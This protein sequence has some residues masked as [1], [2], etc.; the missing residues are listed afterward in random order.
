M[1]R[2]AQPVPDGFELDPVTGM[3]RVKARNPF[4]IDASGSPITSPA[5]VAAQQ[6]ALPT[7][8]TTTTQATSAAPATTGA[9]F[10]MPTAAVSTANARN[11]DDP[12]RQGPAGP[13]TEPGTGGGTNP[14][15]S[16]GTGTGDRTGDR[17]ATTG[18]APPTFTAAST[19][20]ELADFLN[21]NRFTPDQA[22]DIVLQYVKAHGLSGNQGNPNGTDWGVYDTARQKYYVPNADVRNENGTWTVHPW[23]T[24]DNSTSTG[25]PTFQP[26]QED[27]AWH[28]AILK[29]LEEGNTPVDANDPIIKAQTDAARVA[30]TREIATA[31]NAAAERAA[32]EGLPTGAFD[33][34]I[35]G[36]QE[37][38]GENL[39]GLQATLMANELQARRAK[40]VNALNFASGEDARSL[41]AYL[42]NIDAVL[43]SLG[44]TNQNQQHYDDLA[45]EYL[46]EQD[47]MRR[48]YDSQS[49]P[50]SGA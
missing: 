43:R 27:P 50:P 47:L 40:V 35:T 19:P 41:Q 26:W 15:G 3:P 48:F 44:L 23:G 4:A 11:P 37:K 6:P 21:K 20:Q 25:A 22:R 39:S 42:G 1:A 13:G 8:A 5:T 49:T 33:A 18:G 7:P 32:A 36:N 12:G 38:L 17:G 29:L 10:S 28:A 34:A 30:G 24:G 9:T 16:P 31:R 2:I 46:R 45:L 14:P